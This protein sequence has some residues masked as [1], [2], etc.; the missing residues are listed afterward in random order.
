GRLEE[1]VAVLSEGEPLEVALNPFFMLEALRALSCEE[2]AIEFTG[3]LSAIT[4][5]PA[6]RTSDC[7]SLLLPIRLL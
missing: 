6:E 2:A 3:P 4:F 5:R 1:R 7:F